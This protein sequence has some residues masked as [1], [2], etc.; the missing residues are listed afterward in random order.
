M[1]M[2]TDCFYVY[3]GFPVAITKVLSDGMAEIRYIERRT[4]EK[5]ETVPADKLKELTEELAV[6]SINKL[7][8]LRDRAAG[9]YNVVIHAYEECLEYM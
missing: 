2:K 9:K 6:S 3:N 1:I 7:C 8:K 4:Q 5:I